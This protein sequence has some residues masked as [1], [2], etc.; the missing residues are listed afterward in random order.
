MGKIKVRVQPG[1]SRN[2]VQGF[3]DEVLRIKLTAPPVEGKANKALIAMLAATLRVS[4][5]SVTIVAGQS[6]REKLVEVD[7][8]SADELKR[9][10]SE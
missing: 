3:Q 7:G 8:L 10:L 4:K 5:T 2:E 9:R 6:G 1:A